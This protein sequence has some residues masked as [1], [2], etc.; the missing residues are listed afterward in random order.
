[1]Y[2][3]FLTP[4]PLL[5]SL[6]YL[7]PLDGYECRPSLSRNVHGLASAMSEL[8][9][10]S[11]RQLLVDRYDDLR[12]R[13]TRRLGSDDLARETL[14]ETYLR[15][16]RVECSRAIHNPVAYLFRTALNLAIDRRRQDQRRAQNSEIR[17]A[18]D[19]ADETPGQEREVE[20]RRQ[21][22]TLQRL[23]DE[24]PW[25]Q[26]AILIAVR[27]KNTPHQ[28]LADRYGISKRMVQFELKAA[29]EF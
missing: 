8:P 25:R 28:E 19:V 1:M 26:R 12:L 2:Y 13:L 10:S 4:L 21:V 22:E 9:W 5:F 6:D 23:V 15:L 27:L 20:G 16:D 24:L 29:L 18:L 3:I 7:L 14:H 17:E 11:L